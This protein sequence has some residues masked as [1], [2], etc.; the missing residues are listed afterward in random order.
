MNFWFI[1]SGQSPSSGAGIPVGRRYQTHFY[2]FGHIGG[3]PAVQG[4]GVHK[5]YEANSSH[6]LD[7]HPEVNG[8]P[9]KNNHQVQKLK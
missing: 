4:G 7:T 3:L 2:K 5:I 8:H 9:L 6:F 1:F